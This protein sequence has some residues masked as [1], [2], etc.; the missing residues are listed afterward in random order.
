MKF[1]LQTVIKSNTKDGLHF[2]YWRDDVFEKPV[3]V[4]KNKAAVNCIIDP[5]AEN[6]FGTLE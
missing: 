4:A 5:V 3:F 1:S 6:I 2:G